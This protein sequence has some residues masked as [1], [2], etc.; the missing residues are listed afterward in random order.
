MATIEPGGQNK[1]HQ[2]KEEE[3][4]ATDFYCLSGIKEGQQLK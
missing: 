3:K 4:L 2:M 1:V